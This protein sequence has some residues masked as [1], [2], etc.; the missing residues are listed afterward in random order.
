MTQDFLSS[1]I[2]D[3]FTNIVGRPN[4]VAEHDDIQR[5]I[6]EPRNIFH[7]NTPLVVKPGSVNEVSK[8]LQLAN[9]HNIPI[10]PQGGNTGLVGGQIPDK[11]EIEV[12]LSLERMNKI[13]NVDAISNVLTVEAGVI[14]EVI[15]E[16]AEELDRIFP[17]YLSSQGSCQIG[18]NIATNAGGTGVLAYGNTRDMILGLEVVLATGE[19]WNGLRT[20]RKDNTGYDLKQIFIGSE[21]TLGII[22]AANLRLFPKPKS[23]DIA[24]VG[25]KSPQEALQLYKICAGNSGPLLTAF[26]LIPRIGLDFSLKHLPNIKD[27]LHKPSPWYVLVELSSNSTSISTRN[28]IENIFTQAETQNLIQDAVLAENIEH[29]NSFWH[30]RHSLSE[31]QKFEGGS[32][33]HDISVPIAD[34]PAF[35]DHA[36]KTV[37]KFIPDCRPFAFGH[38]GDGNIHFN[39]SQPVNADK[40]DFLSKWSEVNA[41]VNEIVISFNGS[42]SAEHG[43]GRLK[44][45]LLAETKSDIELDMMKRIKREFDPNGILNRGRIFEIET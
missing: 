15:H 6:V 37:L 28:L 24:F 33:K 30:L 16:I 23:Q 7:G 34:I 9:S 45:N 10:V 2:S 27:P 21:G 44:R 11:T 14:L 17:L 32:I 1:I 3:Q 36:S 13:R 19:I 18:G 42:I 29:R 38:M 43:I 25:I 31:V 20:L 5:Y 40:E 12:V 8:I 26:E 35:L 22:T 39:V 41:L 4:I